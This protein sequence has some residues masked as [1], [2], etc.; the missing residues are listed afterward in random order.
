MT[1]RLTKAERTERKCMFCN[2]V[3]TPKKG[4]KKGFYCNKICSSRSNGYK[5][6]RSNLGITFDMNTPTEHE[7]YY[8]ES[9][10]KGGY[11][12]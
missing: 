11:D 4:A 2:A 6:G 10:D 8:D 9:I 5:V 12:F 7:I 3:F 1:K